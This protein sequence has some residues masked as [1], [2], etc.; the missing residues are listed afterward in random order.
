MWVDYAIYV[1]TGLVLLAG[2]ALIVVLARNRARPWAVFTLVALV[3][4]GLVATVVVRPERFREMGEDLVV[5]DV[6]GAL[7]TEVDLIGFCLSV[8]SQVGP[9]SFIVGND[10]FPGDAWDRGPYTGCDASGHSGAIHLPD[11]VRS[12]G[13]M[14]CDYVSC[15]QLIPSVSS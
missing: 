11:S 7:Q 14:L 4:V 12:G 10:L 1:T 6:G 9:L 15:H 3:L 13:W 2:I 5:V 8:F